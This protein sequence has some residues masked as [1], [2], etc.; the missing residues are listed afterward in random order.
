ML[1]VSGGVDSMVLL[2]LLHKRPGVTFTVAHFNH[3][4]REDAE[5]DKQLVESVA[6]R[7]GAPFVHHKGNLGSG[8]SEAAAREARYDFLHKVKAATGA[9]AIITAHHQDDLIETAFLNMLR[10]TGRRGLSSLKSTDGI[11]RPLLPFSKERIKDYAHVNKLAWREDSTNTD[12]KYKRNQVRHQL[13][14]KLTV[15]QREQLR[16]LL[17]DIASLNETIDNE[18]NTL[19]HVQPAV[20]TL[21]RQWFI[22]LPHSVAREVLH[23]WLKRHEVPQVDRR[24]LEQLTATLKTA[25]PNTTHHVSK[26]HHLELTKSKVHI[27]NNANPIA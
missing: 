18:L 26:N 1:A 27:K 15:G 4:I 14:P 23:Q 16:I 12:M 7:L 5:Q 10:G 11:I 20:H 24:R 21:D 6:R 2:D 19:L 9:Q 22:M 8:V 3:G 17:E 13:L 25:R